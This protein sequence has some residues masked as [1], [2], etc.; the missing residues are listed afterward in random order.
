[1]SRRNTARGFT[2]LEVLI[3]IAILG[4][5]ATGV[6]LASQKMTAS[7][8]VSAAKAERQTLQKAVDAMMAEA[9]T[10]ETNGLVANGWTG[11]EGVVTAGTTS[12]DANAF[13][14]RT[15]TK[16]HFGVEL[17]GTVWC[18]KY[19]GISD[20]TKVNGAALPAGIISEP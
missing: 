20:L 14:K 11:G 4:V 7:A 13:L 9:R 15:P 5:I 3:V 6:V 18:T 19:S 16:G 10:T 2:L 8:A 17:D 12:V 1:M